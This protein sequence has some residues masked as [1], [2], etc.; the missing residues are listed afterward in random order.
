MK[1]PAFETMDNIGDYY[2]L[3]KMLISLRHKEMTQFK[4]EGRYDNFYVNIR[5]AIVPPK[6]ENGFSCSR[7]WRQLG[8][9]LIIYF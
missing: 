9:N 4:T 3:K 7:R 5:G 2:C 6:A 8:S 1:D